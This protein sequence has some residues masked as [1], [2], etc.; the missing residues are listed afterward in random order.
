MAQDEEPD[1]AESMAQDEEPDIA[2]EQAKAR[3]DSGDVE[4]DEPME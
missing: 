2:S 4:E 1:I 3:A